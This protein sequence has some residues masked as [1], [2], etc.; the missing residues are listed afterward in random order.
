MHCQ[1]KLISETQSQWVE[2]LAPVSVQ[3]SVR[4]APNTF[5]FPQWEKKQ[6]WEMKPKNFFSHFLALLDSFLS[7]VFLH[8]SKSLTLI[9]MKVTTPTQSLFL[10]RI[11]TVASHFIHEICC[12]LF[13][14]RCQ[15]NGHGINSK[16]IQR[17]SSLTS[18]TS[19]SSSS[20]SFQYFF[21][22]PCGTWNDTNVNRSITESMGSNQPINNRPKDPLSGG[23]L[24]E[25]FCTMSVVNTLI[26]DA[27]RCH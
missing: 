4:Y 23:E 13:Q 16:M 27:E 11:F 26:S 3:A 9:S 20:S 7:F 2:Q 5:P 6:K 18:S 15:N 10:A 24:S 14:S 1:W 8:R 17:P 21:I 25:Y 12:P 19:S 22:Y